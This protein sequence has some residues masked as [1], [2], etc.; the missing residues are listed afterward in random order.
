MQED[1][2]AHAKQNQEPV[3]VFLISDAE[4]TSK[5]LLGNKGA[6]LA[7]MGTL[8]L[9]VPPG[10][11]IT[12]EA[13]KE[14]RVEQELSEKLKAEIAERLK[15]VEMETGRRFGA[16]SNPLLVSVRSGAPVSM[17]GM[18]D[19]ILNLGLNDLTVT[20]LAD[21]A[22]D[23]M[24]AYDCYQRFVSSFARIALGIRGD[25]FKE[26]AE[27]T[28]Q[29]F[30]LK[31][32]EVMP[33]NALK[34]IIIEYKALVEKE[35]GNKFPDDVYDQLFQA[36]RAVF[37]SWFSERAVE[38]RHAQNI[39]EN[40][41]TAVIVQ[42]MVFGNMGD[43]SGTGVLFTRDPS[44]GQK[45]LFG[46]FLL[47]AQGEDIVSGVRTP[48]PIDALRE[49]LPAIYDQLVRA[50][51]TLE[52][53]YRDMQ[54]IEFTIE[55]ERLYLLQTRNG[56]RTAQAA[57]RIAFDMFKEGIMSREQAVKIIRSIPI[58]EFTVRQKDPNAKV[59]TL[60]KGLPAS[61]GIATGIVVFDSDEAERLKEEGKS[62]ILVRPK[63]SP[64]DI[65]GIMA[66]EGVVTA[67]GGI[68]SHAAVI[69]R[70]LGKPCVVG[71][72]EIEVDVDTGRFRVKKGEYETVSVARGELISI[73]GAEG[74]V[75][76]GE[77]PLLVQTLSEY[78]KELLT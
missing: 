1:N 29:K 46:E 78:V 24:F 72:E 23:E 28:A 37:D 76:R 61:P 58:E 56:K 49:K 22:E 73:D 53:H 13:W 54:D 52:L 27:K 12:T 38:Y 3:R 57:A 26:I 21:Q 66:A 9:P 15:A 7:E 11:I 16:L 51:D 43:N 30:N 5:S 45:K 17:P 34:E 40:L 70:G 35:T 18:M 74:I 64:E 33:V 20:K 31:S 4:A 65:R 47:N 59:H 10:I 32:N 68:T 44:T 6:E 2:F 39:S 55:K 50:A 63:T 42:S 69:T 77:I 19:S 75:V 60:T 14:Y 62:V 25:G 48:E 41:G 71:C 67:K 36:V 8:R